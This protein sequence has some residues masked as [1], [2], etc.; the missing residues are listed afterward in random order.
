M[1]SEL[2]SPT[3]RAPC[4]RPRHA[5]LRPPA[6]ACPI[7]RELACPAGG[8]K[9]RPLIASFRG[10]GATG[11]PHVM[12]APGPTGRRGLPMGRTAVTL[13]ESGNSPRQNPMNVDPDQ[14]QQL[15]A[16]ASPLPLARNRAQQT[17]EQCGAAARIT[18]DLRERAAA[19]PVGAS[20][21][22]R[23]TALE[24]ADTVELLGEALGELELPLPADLASRPL[25]R[26][27]R[28]RSP[29]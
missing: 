3:G 29:E 11:V 24:G 2:H 10:I 17:T 22:P 26:R 1:A 19:P 18:R 7:Q 14:P 4:P 21:R 6:F 25:R 20:R 23:E 28:P 15:Y 16:I 9:K 27:S 12:L 8:P 5:L 13:S